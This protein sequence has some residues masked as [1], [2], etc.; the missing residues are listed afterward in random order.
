MLI[1]YY[2]KTRKPNTTPQQLPQSGFWLSYSTVRLFLVCPYKCFTEKPWVKISSALC[3]THSWEVLR[4]TVTRFLA[5]LHTRS[6]GEIHAK[7]GNENST[8]W[9]RSCCGVFRVEIEGCCEGKPFCIACCGNYTIVLV[10]KNCTW[11]RCAW[12]SGWIPLR[13][14]IVGT[15][16]LQGG[17]GF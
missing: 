5:E 13:S 17:M 14:V 2:P 7:K 16:A 6:E 9:L 4:R 3:G 12:V 1:C 10:L 8:M 15:T 11:N